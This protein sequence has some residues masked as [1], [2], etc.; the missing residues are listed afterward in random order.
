MID[1]II[2]SGYIKLFIKEL[3]KLNKGQGPQ[4]T[5]TTEDTGHTDD[6]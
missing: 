6:A 4:I 2:I 1:K 3:Q 5:E